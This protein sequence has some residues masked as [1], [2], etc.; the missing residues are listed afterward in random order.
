MVVTGTEG[1]SRRRVLPT[2][3]MPNVPNLMVSGKLPLRFRLVQQPRWF[4]LLCCT[5]GTYSMQRA[6][7][8]LVK[9]TAPHDPRLLELSVEPHV[10]HFVCAV[11]HRCGPLYPLVSSG[12]TEELCAYS[13]VSITLHAFTCRLQEDSQC[14]GAAARAITRVLNDMPFWRRLWRGR[15]AGGA[16]LAPIGPHV[17][18]SGMYRCAASRATTNKSAGAHSH[19]LPYRRERCY[20]SISIVPGPSPPV[21]REPASYLIFPSDEPPVNEHTTQSC[22]LAERDCQLTSLDTTG[23]PPNAR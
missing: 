4:P 6:A 17:I 15:A 10:S 23:C 18:M 3:S 5:K 12:S 20:G 13:S 11:M 16:Q 8:L 9:S 21:V 14:M 2:L 22:L 7:V 19:L 1:R